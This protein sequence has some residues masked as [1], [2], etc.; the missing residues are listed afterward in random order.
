MKRM[1][2]LIQ[3]LQVDEP[4]YCGAIIKE[5]NVRTSFA[6]IFTNR[7]ELCQMNLDTYA[8]SRQP[9]FVETE[10]RKAFKNAVPLRTVVV[11][12]YDPR[13]TMIPQAVAKA[14]SGE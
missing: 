8:F 14:M 5:P 13:A 6:A 7:K 10:M 11:Y 3:Q 12:C 2:W 9:G 4:F 1:P